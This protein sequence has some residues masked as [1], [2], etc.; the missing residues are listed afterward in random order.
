MHEKTFLAGVKASIAAL[1][2][3]AAF[4]SQSTR[5][6]TFPSSPLTLTVAYPAGGGADISSRALAGPLQKLLGQTVVVE[7]RGGAGG[8]IATQGFLQQKPDGY[9]LL[10]LTGNEALMN[11]IVLASTRYDPKQLR[12]IHPMIFSDLVLVTGKK[13]APSDIDS[14]IR[15]IQKP[16]TPE[17]SFGN[18][19]IGSPPHLAAADFRTQA[20]VG[21]L[22][23]QY[24]GVSPIVQDLIGGQL[25]YAFLPLIASV[26]DMI[27]SDRLKAV[28][29]A[30]TTR[31]PLLPDV[32]AAGES[33]VLKDFDYHVWPAVFVQQDTPEP[34]VQKLHQAVSQVI[35]GDEYQRWSVSTGN[36]PMTAMTLEQAADF[37]RTELERV[38][39]LSVVLNIKPQ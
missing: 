23:V 27:R 4:G 31:H 24:K 9:R 2:A 29:M 34:I 8:S 5:A 13:D 21:S 28:S 39:R 26:L 12:L 36:R 38:K 10:A 22:D 3:A 6:D 16:G 15:L 20:N 32:P 11:P 33:K 7:N 37:Y 30:T 18:W 19:G 14:L 25:D 1:L 17:Y 35:N